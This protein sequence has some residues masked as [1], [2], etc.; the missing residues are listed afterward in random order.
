MRIRHHFAMAFVLPLA[1]TACV[2]FGSD[3]EEVDLDLAMP[4]DTY[5]NC[6]G[7]GNFLT[8]ATGGGSGTVKLG[9]TECEL[10]NA[11]GEAD[12]ITPQFAREGERRII[13]VYANP[14]GGSTAYLFVQN[15]LKEINRIK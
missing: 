10:S 5:D 13:M 6:G 12:E 9:M 3:E 2:S 1:L 14:N 4:T 15:A 11:L 7:A 8:S